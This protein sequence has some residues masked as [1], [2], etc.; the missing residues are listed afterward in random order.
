[1]EVMSSTPNLSQIRPKL[2]TAA[3]VL[4]FIQAF[5]GFSTIY[6]S[7]RLLYFPLLGTAGGALL[8]S[9]LLFTFLASAIAGMGFL[10]MKRWAIY[11]CILQ[12]VALAFEAIVF[13][14]VPLAG[15]LQGG[16]IFSALAIIFGLIH[17]G[18]MNSLNWKKD[19]LFWGITIIFI[20]SV[21]LDIIFLQFYASRINSPN[22]LDSIQNNLN[23]LL[24]KFSGNK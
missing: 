11:F 7:F 10:K 19:P 6:P 18:K 21:V 5:F 8:S 2:V 20:L 12:F 1:M 9:A 22:S 15:S 23:T 3:A 4:L 24:Q 14:G 16:G 13:A 17:I